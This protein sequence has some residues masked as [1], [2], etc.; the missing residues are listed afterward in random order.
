MDEG[1]M[2]WKIPARKLLHRSPLSEAFVLVWLRELERKNPSTTSP[3]RVSPTS[4]RRN[5]WPTPAHLDPF[6]LGTEM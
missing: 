5:F 6:P 3:N 2:P 1:P 4:S